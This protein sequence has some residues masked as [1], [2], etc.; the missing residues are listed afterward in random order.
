MICNIILA[1]RRLIHN[2]EHSKTHV[3]L[4]VTAHNNVKFLPAS[5]AAALLYKYRF[6]IGSRNVLKTYVFTIMELFLNKKTSDDY[7]YKNV[8]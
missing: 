8:K 4:S 7:F 5:T 3:T 2:Q 6:V 1:R